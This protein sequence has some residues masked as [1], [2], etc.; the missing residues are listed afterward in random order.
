MDVPDSD[1]LLQ[2]ETEDNGGGKIFQLVFIQKNGVW[3]QMALGYNC[4]TLHLTILI[5]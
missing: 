4:T 2:E 3:F 1:T 5:Q